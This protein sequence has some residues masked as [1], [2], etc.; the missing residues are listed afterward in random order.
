V[1]YSPRPCLAR[2]LAKLLAGRRR[3]ADA[4]RF[5]WSSAS[6][7]N[8]VDV[9]RADITTTIRERLHSVEQR[10]GGACRRAGRDR[11]QVTLVAV[12]KTVSVETAALAPALGLVNLGENR[13]QELWRKAAALPT[14]VRWH[15]IGHLQRNKIDK[16]LSL[17]SMIHSVDSVR[18]LRALED[19][20][21]RQGRALDVLLEI[22]ASGEAAKHGFAPNEVLSLV[23]TVRQLKQVRVRGLM[24]MAA[25]QQPQACRPTFR[26]L[27]NLRDRLADALG[28]E[29]PHLSMGMSND[30]EIAVEE[31]AT[32]VRLGSVLFEG[33][34]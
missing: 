24:T 20:A 5:H 25:L 34:P 10:L 21:A 3:A 11:A 19:E 27:R 33:L 29:L 15:L 4:G 13:P 22:N 30:F 28:F 12:T 26:L 16:T 32:L 14:S 1:S 2:L 17:A 7:A 8:R 9:N 23:P 6:Y 18:L 31:G